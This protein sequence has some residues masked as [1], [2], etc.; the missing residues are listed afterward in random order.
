MNL[1]FPVSVLV[2]SLVLPLSAQDVRIS[3]PWRSKTTPVQKH[4]QEGVKALKKNHIDDAKK[5]FYKAYL[6]DP[7][8]PFTLNNLGYV[9]E[10]EGDIDR[11]TRYYDLAAANTSEAVVQS[12]SMKDVEG[13]PVSQVA[14]RTE[15]GPLEVNRKNVRAIGLLQKDRP[16]EAQRVLE[17]ALALQPNNPFTLNNLGFALEKQGE[18]QAALDRYNQ[19]GRTNSREKVIVTV[20]NRRQWRGREISEVAKENADEVRRQ[21]E[22]QPTSEEQVARLNLRGVS[23]L[24]RND[25]KAARSFFEQANKLDPNNAFTLN[26]MGYLAEL[27]GDKETANYLYARARAAEASGTVVGVATRREAEGKRLERVAIGNEDVVARR[28]EQERKLR[29]Q[30]NEPVQLKR[31]DGSVV[32]EPVNPSPPAEQQPPPPEEPKI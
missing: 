6:L 14:G 15:K 31:R 12:A 29:Q 24:N 32:V 8:D 22:E 10:L 3:I 2:L 1:R 13:K 27:D 23:A 16:M 4:N 25:R 28:M 20:D 5:S 21:L 17:Q 9:A 7:N 19:A 30:L 11:A 18:L 26:N